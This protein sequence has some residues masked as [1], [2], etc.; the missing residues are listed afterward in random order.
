MWNEEEGCKEEEVVDEALYSTFF[1]AFRRSSFGLKFCFCFC[2][3][4]ISIGLPLFANLLASCE[5]LLATTKERESERDSEA[6]AR[7]D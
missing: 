6:S 3:A 2:F 4:S 7:L 1:K 5:L